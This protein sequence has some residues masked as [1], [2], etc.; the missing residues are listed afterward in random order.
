MRLKKTELIV[1]I[2]DRRQHK[3]ILTKRNLAWSALAFVLLFA[4][5]LVQADLRR[6]ADA[7]YGR[8]FGSQV[9]SQDSKIAANQDVVTEA[10]VPES[11][12]ADPMLVAPG[13]R[14]QQLLDNNSAAA[15]KPIV[16]SVATVPEPAPVKSTAARGEHVTIVGGPEGVSVVKEK[17]AKPELGGGFGH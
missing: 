10:P 3:R 11:S 9:P 13:A 2:R 17:N 5:I 14:E 12:G 7:G 8:L 1:P 15:Q 16:A 4:V 6:G